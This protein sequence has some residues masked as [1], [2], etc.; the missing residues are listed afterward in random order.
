LQKGLVDDAIYVRVAKAVSDADDDFRLAR[1]APKFV[2]VE[3][4][5]VHELHFVFDSENE[6]RM[7][8]W[9]SSPGKPGPR[10][11]AE[12]TSQPPMYRRQREKE[13]TQRFASEK[14]RRR[15]RPAI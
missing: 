10:S 6:V 12:K 9:K 1:V 13:K 4:I 2:G 8:S 5:R 14:E 15:A 11:K 7:G 3:K